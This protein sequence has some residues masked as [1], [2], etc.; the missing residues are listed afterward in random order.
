MVAYAIV[1]VDVHDIADYLVHQQLL[2]P[3]L[4]SAEIGRASGRERV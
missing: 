3:L 1:E 2:V 4:Q